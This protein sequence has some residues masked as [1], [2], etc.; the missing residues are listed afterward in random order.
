M[1]LQETILDI[2]KKNNLTQ[3][4]LADKLFVTRQAVSRWETGETTPTMDT[5]KNLVKIFNVDTNILLGLGES[6]ICQSCSMALNE[7][8]NFGTNSDNTINTEYCTHCFRNGS[9][10]HNRTIDEMVETNLN[11]LDE[12]NSENNTS[13]SV[14]E[15]RTVLKDH[16]ATLNRWKTKK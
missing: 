1:E 7:I 2:R 11:F 12:F 6:P 16:L 13:Y 3:K 5:L 9:F 8:I 10:T 14:E 15:A 4:E